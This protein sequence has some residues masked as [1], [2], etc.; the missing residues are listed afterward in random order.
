MSLPQCLNVDVLG[1]KPKALCSK[2]ELRP[3]LFLSNN[4]TYAIDSRDITYELDHSCTS[5]S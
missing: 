5:T 3:N 4:T 2:R 1:V